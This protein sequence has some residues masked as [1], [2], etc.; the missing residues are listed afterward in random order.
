MHAA[1][2]EAARVD[3]LALVAGRHEQRADTPW[4]LELPARLAAFAST[5]ICNSVRSWI[6]ST[7]SPPMRPSSRSSAPR[8]IRP[9][10]PRPR[11]GRSARSW[12][13]QEDLRRRGA[14]TGR[15]CVRAGRPRRPGT[16]T[17]EGSAHRRPAGDALAKANGSAEPSTCARPRPRAPGPS[18]ARSPGRAGRTR[19]PSRE[20]PAPRPPR[21]RRAGALQTA[22]AP[23]RSASAITSTRRPRLRRARPAPP[24]RR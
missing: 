24:G 2:V 1:P 18:P 17:R 23:S 14:L 5:A 11:A 13:P 6:S 10:R 4:L 15:P 22:P 20:T 16:S 12:R 3:D 19:R 7:I 21:R 8:S 9:W